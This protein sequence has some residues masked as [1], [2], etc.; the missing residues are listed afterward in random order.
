SRPRRTSS[1]ARGLALAELLVSL[2]PRLPRLPLRLEVRPGAEGASSPAPPDRR[3]PRTS[4]PRRPCLRRSRRS[5]SRSRSGPTR[6]ARCARATLGRARGSGERGSPHASTSSTPGRWPRREPSHGPTGCAV[7]SC[8][9]SCL[10]LAQGATA[11]A[12][13]HQAHAEHERR[14][15]EDRAVEPELIALLG[16]LDAHV[17]LDVHLASEALLTAQPAHGVEEEQRVV[18]GL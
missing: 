11:G 15:A 7:A 6:A 16:V 12:S 5:A 10:R 9:S 2:L 17:L 8:L 14:C 18:R 1:H 4:A 3:E 13:E